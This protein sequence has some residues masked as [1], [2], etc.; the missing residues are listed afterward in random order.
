MKVPFILG[1]VGHF[2]L[3]VRDPKKSAKW[4]ERALGLTKQ[5]EY[6]GGIAVGND[7]VT[8]ALGLGAGAES[9]RPLGVAVVGGLI[10]SQLLTLYIT[11]VIYLYLEKLH[12]QQ[13][14]KPERVRQM[15][16][17]GDQPI[18]PAPKPVGAQ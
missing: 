3:A 1:Q 17:R 5:F 11:P 6:E 9:R 10:F 12:G 4:F 16:E 2:G 7:H 8:I 14:Q 15:F 13:K 18:R